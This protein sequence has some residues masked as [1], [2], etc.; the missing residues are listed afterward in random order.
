MESD[1]ISFIFCIYAY[2]L[3]NIMLVLLRPVSINSNIMIIFLTFFFP[4]WG[5]FG[6]SIWEICVTNGWKKDTFSY[7]KIVAKNTSNRTWAH[8]QLCLHSDGP[9]TGMHL[10]VN[11]MFHYPLRRLVPRP[12][13][14]EERVWLRLADPSGFI[15]IEYFLER[16][17]PPPTTLQ[18]T[19]P[20]VATPEI[21]GYVSMTK[22]HF[23]GA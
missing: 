9:I 16:N 7:R 6:P 12:H 21:H 5:I 23:F 18:K 20:I 10:A 13:P 14:R 4:K 22:Q 1:N 2:E 11:V 15:N 8:P 17:F 3:S 19:Q